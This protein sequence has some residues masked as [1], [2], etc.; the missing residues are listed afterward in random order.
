MGLGGGGVGG[1]VFNQVK[2]FIILLYHLINA[3]VQVETVEFSWEIEDH[4]VIVN[5]Y[6]T[7]LPTYSSDSGYCYS[8]GYILSWFSDY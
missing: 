8:V 7:D 4:V 6:L 1:F 3:I 2:D 5:S